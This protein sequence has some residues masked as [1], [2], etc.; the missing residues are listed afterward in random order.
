M[1]ILLRVISFKDFMTR[2]R[3]ENHVY[4]AKQIFI[5]NVN[6]QWKDSSSP[7]LHQVTISGD[8]D[9]IELLSMVV[10]Q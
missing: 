10:Y 6:I 7:P 3:Q 5:S 4:F 2:V 9:Y 8:L 1:T